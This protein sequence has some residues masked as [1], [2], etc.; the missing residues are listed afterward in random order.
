[1]VFALALQATTGWAGLDDLARAG[2][3]S[4]LLA[5]A[6]RRGEQLPLTS[7]E[8]LVAAK[9]ARV[10]GKH[11]A[12]EFFLVRASEGGPLA[13]V[14]QLELAE[15]VV[16]PDGARAVVLVVPLIRGAPTYAMRDAAVDVAVEALARGLDPE[17]RRLLES[18]ARLASR[19][20]RRR[21]ELA[22][23]ASDG[24]DTRERLGRL[25]ASSTLDLVA[26]QAAR[27]LRPMNNLSN[28]ERWWVAQ[29]LYRHALYREAEPIL[30]SLDGVS[31][32]TIPGSQVMFLRGRCAFRQGGWEEAMVWYERAAAVARSD[33]ER[34][35]LEVHL[36]RSLELRGRLEEALAAAQR[37]VQSRTTDDRRLFLARL[38]LRLNQPEF[39]AQGISRLRGRTARARGEL[40]LALYDVELGNRAAARRRLA[41]IRRRPWSGPAAVVASRLA[42]DDGAPQEALAILERAALELDP[43]WS[44]VARSL[45]AE[46]PELEVQAWRARCLAA[47]EAT[48]GRAR[49][50]V[51]A[52]W[53]RL[54]ASQEGLTRL[55]IEVARGLEF[56]GGDA[57]PPF[58]PGVAAE[59]WR[60]GL[61]TGAVRWDP[62]GMPSRDVRSALWS[63]RQ[64]EAL[65]VSDRA[66]RSADAAWRMAG[67]EI[68]VRAYP[69]AFRRTLYPLP[70]SDV[71]WRAAVDNE[72]P[73]SLV[74]A[75]A[76]EESRWQPRAI[77][78]V[79]ARGLMQLMPGTAADVA[80]LNGAQPPDD[81]RLFDPKVSLGLGASEIGR[82]LEVFV[83][84]WAPA[85][86]AYNAGEAQARLWLEDCGADCTE[87]LFVAHVTFT[88]TSQ[89]TRDVLVGA[90]AYAE[91][92]GSVPAAAK[93]AVP[94]ALPSRVSQP[95]AGS[96]G[97]R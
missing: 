20:H 19:G 9:A 45:M 58:T 48:D 31:S 96:G 91:L 8:A 18:E 63:A 66:I 24:D 43:Y 51:L 83:D 64:F 82:L 50:E 69:E 14:A 21:L 7:E 1:M 16:D 30:K 52:R 47:V 70:G 4:E 72:V 5:V 71:V 53:A 6:T 93:E 67:A 87:E 56:E 15:L 17:S 80:S 73:W 85:V 34:A 44:R 36:A 57:T 12:E 40:L 78:R 92:Y 13:E 55:R 41:A 23:L 81:E 90:A 39:A 60:I 88:S 75:V 37:A 49:Q 27:L 46:L 61:T 32:R 10:L 29:T 35:D 79:G 68:P 22:L 38:R 11:E 28:Q 26:L 42:F 62:T 84:R 74:A 3:W 94:S 2:R 97:V 33:E 59:L 25:L 76:R 77:S 86:A 54:E 89:Y 95:S 65:G